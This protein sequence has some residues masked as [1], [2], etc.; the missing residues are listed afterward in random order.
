MWAGP[1]LINKWPRG[2]EYLSV[3]VQQLAS[4][5]A[6]ESPL[7]MSLHKYFKRALPTSEET[8]LGEATT[9][10]V[11]RS[12][13]RVL[14]GCE[15]SAK[16]PRKE[17]TVYSDTDRAAIGK[18]AAENGNTSAQKHF[19]EKFPELGESTVRSFKQK[20]LSLVAGGK[21]SIASIPT[22]RMGRP[23]ALG[24]LD[25]EVQKYIRAL[26]AAGTAI[27]V[28]LVLAAAQGI[29][30]AKDRTLL[31]EN[32]GSINL[33]RSWGNSLMQ[34]M[35]FVRRAATTQ[36]KRQV[37]SVAY[38]QIKTQYLRQI[39]SMVAVHKIPS[40]LVINWDQTSIAVVPSIN[41]SMAQ[42]GS[43]RVEVAAL[44]DKRQVTSTLAVTLN[45]QFLPFQVLYQ[46]KTDRCHPSYTFPDDFDIFHTPNHWANGMTVVRYIEN[47][48]LPHVR[49]VRSE[50]S[51]PDQHGL[52]IFDVFRG[53]LLPEVDEVLEEN[54][55]L[56]VVVPS[57][58]TDR[59][60][61]LDLSANKAL[62]DQL[63][64]SFQQWYAQQVSKQL[65][66]GKN[67]E[68]VN[69]DMR[70]SV[71]KELQA[72]WMVSAYDY[73]HANP[74]IGINGFKEAGIVAA[75]EDPDSIAVSADEDPFTEL[76]EEDPFAD[77]AEEE[78]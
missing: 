17:R 2:Y 6:C 25:Q 15:K 44:N 78:N 33:T 22:K 19:K 11:N 77:L 27:S 4:Y 73:L 53:H 28:P 70:L 62:K 43:R 74:Q 72:K 50:L 61:P 52:V 47:I 60:Q 41:W 51:S 45:G 69:V 66:Q 8:G 40:Q 21:S 54:K 14:D 20:Y 12:V 71:V 9:R 63:R 59:L 31:V 26:R 56:K 68:D 24:D 7:K 23:L 57:N 67:L 10:T 42:E 37:T 39:A 49:K 5:L 55:L 38:Q 3:S 48:I 75:I 64:S 34:R 65:Q 18:Y 36:A 46:G 1:G 30:D 76:A 32:G 13:Q 16:K 29:I 58:C 35:G